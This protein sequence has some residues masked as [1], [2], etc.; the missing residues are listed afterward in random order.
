[1]K[2]T[3]TSPNLENTSPWQKSSSKTSYKKEEENN[4]EPKRDP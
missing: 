2:T 1:M 3:W 4:T